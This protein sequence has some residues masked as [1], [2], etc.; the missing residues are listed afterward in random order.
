MRTAHDLKNP[1]ERELG[2][3]YAFLQFVGP[4]SAKAA[5]EGKSPGKEG[6]DGRVE[7]GLPRGAQVHLL[8]SA[9]RL[10]GPPRSPGTRTGGRILTPEEAEDVT[11]WGGRGWEPKAPPSPVLHH[12]PI[13]LSA[14]SRPPARGTSAARA[15]PGSGVRNS[16]AG[17]RSPR[18]PPAP[19][20]GGARRCSGDWAEAR[21]IPKA[22]SPGLLAGP[23]AGFGAGPGAVR[24]QTAGGIKAG[25]GGA[26]IPGCGVGEAVLASR[27]C[28]GRDS[29]KVRGG[30][31]RRAPREVCDLGGGATVGGGGAKLSSGRSESAAPDCSFAE[32]QVLR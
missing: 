12:P 21:R 23:G 22:L 25:P 27:D 15:P 20:R 17:E 10:R 31:W 3:N 5:Q 2:G 8:L 18:F 6:A 9:A 28:G 4:K 24:P 19:W 30:S 16:A 26:L 11:C 13:A 14:P 1:S 32:K 29:G 7:G